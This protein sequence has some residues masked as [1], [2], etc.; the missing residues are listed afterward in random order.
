MNLW[1]IHLLM[2]NI[3]WIIT[4]FAHLLCL[5]YNILI[6][7]NYGTPIE[8]TTLKIS[9]IAIKIFICVIYIWMTYFADH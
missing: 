9:T 3:N 5:I 8:A 2:S 6:Y 7:I 1:Y 4:I